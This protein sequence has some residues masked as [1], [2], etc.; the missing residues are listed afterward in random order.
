MRAKLHYDALDDPLARNA[1]LPCPPP[2]PTQDNPRACEPVS[3]LGWDALNEL[4]ALPAFQAQLQVRRNAKLK[5]LLLD[6]VHMC[7]CVCTR[8]C[9]PLDGLLGVG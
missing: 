5:A 6:Q 1:L 3:T 4:P 7:V 9:A 8:V 2:A